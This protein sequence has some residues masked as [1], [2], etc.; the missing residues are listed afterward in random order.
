MPPPPPPLPPPSIANSERLVM[1]PP[2]L[3]PT[4]LDVSTHLI[5]LPPAPVSEE[6]QPS[7]QSH[8]NDHVVSPAN[9]QPVQRFSFPQQPCGVPPPSD[10]ALVRPRTL[11]TRPLTQNPS[12]QQHHQQRFQRD[13]YPN[14]QPL[15]QNM[16]MLG[17]SYPVPPQNRPGFVVNN[18]GCVPSPVPPPV[19]RFH[20]PVAGSVQTT[21][22]T[23]N[24]V[25][26]DNTA[27]Q[28]CSNTTSST[29][30]VPTYYCAGDDGT[31]YDDKRSGGQASKIRR[32]SG[33]ASKGIMPLMSIS[34][35]FPKKEYQGEH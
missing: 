23:N 11:L 18:V 13:T 3:P 34:T 19:Q 25:S 21:S 6:I 16:A 7:K 8:L 29:S 26:Y 5:P 12:E 9:W 35:G 32:N 27:A 15:G 20:G 4:T 31:W 14:Q 10:M 30:E 24:Q 1:H 22:S 33:G 17:N 2:P 28:P